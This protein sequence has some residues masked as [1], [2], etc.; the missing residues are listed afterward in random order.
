VRVSKVLRTNLVGAALALTFAAG[1]V[2]TAQ[3]RGEGGGIGGS[4]S[5]GGTVS[6]ASGQRERARCQ[7]HFSGEGA[8][9]SVTATCATPSGSVSQ[10]ARL[11]K[12]GPNTYAGSFFNPQYNTSGSISIT[13]HGNTQSVSLRSASGSANLTLRH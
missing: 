7:A 13:V 8:A 5:G 11:R 10:S 6:Y 9:V 3:A 2:S 12:V 1:I 4:W